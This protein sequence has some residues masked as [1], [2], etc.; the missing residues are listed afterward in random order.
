MF[1]Q[2]NILAQCL[3]NSFYSIKSFTRYKW[4]V[5]L[6]VCKHIVKIKYYTHR[7][8]CVLTTKMIN[9]ILKITN[10]KI[11]TTTETTHTHKKYSRAVPTNESTR[12][13]SA[14][15]CACVRTIRDSVVIIIWLI[16]VN[17]WKIR[18]NILAN[19]KYI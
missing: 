8:K 5:C 15:V 11:P 19:N 1:Q 12:Q 13:V 6:F 3:T 10:K 7:I 9:H 16:Y 18:I 14:V 2:V 4:F 17:I